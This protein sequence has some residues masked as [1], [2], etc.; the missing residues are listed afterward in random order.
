MTSR[1]LKPYL[2]AL[3]ITMVATFPL[4]NVL[5][6]PDISRRIAKWAIKLEE[7]RLYY[8][9]RTAIK[10]QVVADFIANF[11]IEQHIETGEINSQNKLDV[12]GILDPSHRW[13]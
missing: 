2:Q 7:Y 12:F 1:K 5:S 8:E 6:K 4:K 11:S 13:L 3:Q 10:S 9:P